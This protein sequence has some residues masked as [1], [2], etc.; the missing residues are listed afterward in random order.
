[1]APRR[2]DRNTPH[3]LIMQSTQRLKD[4]ICYDQL[5]RSKYHYILDQRQVEP[6]RVSGVAPL[7]SQQAGQ[8]PPFALQYLEFTENGGPVAVVKGKHPAKVFEGIYI[9]NDLVMLPELRP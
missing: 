4:A 2:L 7:P 1:M 8:P 5:I 9:L 6:L 3:H